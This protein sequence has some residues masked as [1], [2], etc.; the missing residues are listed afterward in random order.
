MGHEHWDDDDDDED[1]FNMYPHRP[2]YN[3]APNQ[4]RYFP[5]FMPNPFEYNNSFVSN[6]FVYSEC[7]PDD[8]GLY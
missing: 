2:D 3:F 7:G 8:G 5:N 4:N 6:Q 1:D